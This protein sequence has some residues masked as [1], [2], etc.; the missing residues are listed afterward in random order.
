MAGRLLQAHDIPIR[1]AGGPACRYA[2]LAVCLCP[3]YGIVQILHY[4]I[5]VGIG[6][7]HGLVSTVHGRSIVLARVIGDTIQQ[8]FHDV[9]QGL[10]ADA[11]V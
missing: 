1:G 4:P 6:D 8:V 9:F 2:R 7:A 3:P 10:P 5:E 11:F